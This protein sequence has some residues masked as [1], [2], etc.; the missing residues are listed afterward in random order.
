MTKNVLNNGWWIRSR[1]DQVVKYSDYGYPSII[2]LKFH[3]SVRLSF[4]KTDSY[5]NSISIQ[6]RVLKKTDVDR[7]QKVEN[8]LTVY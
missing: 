4:R 3:L 7:F 2:G 1:D 8:I 6:N 5:D